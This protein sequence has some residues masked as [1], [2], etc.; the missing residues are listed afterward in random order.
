MSNT[1][2]YRVFIK[3]KNKKKYYVY[4]IRNKIINKDIVRKDIYE[5]KKAVNQAGLLWGVI[6]IQQAKQH[7]Q[8]YD[9]KML[10]GKYGKQIN[11][12]NE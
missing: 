8:G 7:S 6:D 11:N 2:F 5:L 9:M 1:G 10:Q 4:Q 12:K 3:K